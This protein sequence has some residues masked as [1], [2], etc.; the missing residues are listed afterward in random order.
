MHV[1]SFQN[2]TVKTT[3]KSIAF[4]WNYRQKI[5]WFLFYGPWCTWWSLYHE[6]RIAISFS[7]LGVIEYWT[8]FHWLYA[9]LQYYVKFGDQRFVDLGL[10]TQ[11]VKCRVH[12]N[13]R[14]TSSTEMCCKFCVSSYVPI[15]VTSFYCCCWFSFS[16]I[17]WILENVT[18][19][20]FVVVVCIC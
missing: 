13:F 10:G 2:L 1:S 11:R 7:E 19:W 12:L 15:V 6:C 14:Y 20:K 4:W 3:L 16:G 5:C 18:L 9:V 17:V 8:L